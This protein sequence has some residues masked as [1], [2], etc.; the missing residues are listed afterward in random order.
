M[1]VSVDIFCLVVP[2]QYTLLYAVVY[3]Y[4]YIYIYIYNHSLYRS[5]N[6]VQL[7]TFRRLIWAGHV[8]R[9]EEGRN[10]FKIL[11][12]TPTA[13]IPLGTLRRRWEDNVRMDIKEIGINTKNWVDSAQG[14]DYWRAL[15][16]SVLNLRVP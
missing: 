3:I 11:T 2:N 4:I 7:N 16:N 8:A 14:R 5:P 15:V 9:M 6:I 13:K 1:Y 10:A 12:G